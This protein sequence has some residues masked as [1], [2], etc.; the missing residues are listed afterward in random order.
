MIPAHQRF[1]ARDLE[2][3]EID[4]RLVVEHELLLLH[5][6]AQFAEQGKARRVVLVELGVV[7]GMPAVGMLGR[8]HGHVG[9]LYQDIRVHAVIGVKRN[10]DARAD[11][12]SLLLD[13][14]RRAQRLQQHARG[15]GGVFVAD[16]RQ[17]DGEFV[18]AHARHRI[19]VA[20]FAAQARRDLL[21]QQVADLVTQ[22]IVDVLEAVEIHQQQGERPV[23]AL[24]LFD[25]LLQTLMKQRAVWKLGQRVG[26]RE[27]FE[28]VVKFLQ[29]R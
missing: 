18:T 10:A 22:R 3:L 12:E 14:E 8:V 1:H 27:A 4:L 15:H 6:M 5:R 7:E 26:K 29:S 9:A 21:Q 19:D 28:T 20:Q 13:P 16:R 23:V 11:V 25:R 24:G 17:Q 2:S